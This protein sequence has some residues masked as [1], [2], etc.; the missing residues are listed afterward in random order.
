MKVVHIVPGS[1]GTFYCQNCMRDSTLVQALRRQ[2]FDVVMV[3]M[4]LPLFTDDNPLDDDTPVFF[5]GINVYLQQQ[6]KIF[7]KTPR[8]LDRLFDSM[9]MLKKAAKM[10]GSTSATEMG[11]MTL[12]ML[13][14]SDGNQR[15]EV[16]RLVEW[17]AEHEKPDLVHI[18]NALLIGLAGEIKKV[19]DVPVLCSLQDEDTWLNEIAPPF[20]R[21]CWDAVSERVGDVDRFIA[22]SDWYAD[23]MSKR[24]TI[25][26]ELIEMVHI[27]IDLDGFEPAAMDFDPPVIGYLSK[28]TKQL[29]LGTLV[30]AFIELKQRP[31]LENL[32]L[33]ATGGQV[34]DDKHFIARLKKKL[35]KYGFEAAAEFIPDFSREQRIEFLRSLSVMSVPVEQG[36]AFGT[37]IIE[38]L[39]CGVPVVQP[40]AGAF[41]ELIEATGGGITYDDDLVEA[42]SQLLLNPDRARELGR[43]GRAV[44]Q[45]RFSIETMSQKMMAI[46]NTL[47]ATEKA[48]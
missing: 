48:E 31:G 24:L 13:E 30:D 5:G 23:Q 21:A 17:L 39:A 38:A 26:R 25:P 8:W 28:M 16:E 22:V 40:N 3:P 15:K 18:S 35:A 6:F 46:Y 27:G 45:E 19:L 29:G 2:G 47:V 7:R 4:Y 42:L 36:E 32:K 11:P 34:G 10:E 9:W 12:S 41:P 33:K 37:Y 44:V 14:G 20:D 1:G 43:N